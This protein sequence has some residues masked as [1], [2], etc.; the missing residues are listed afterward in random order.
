M[1]TEKKTWLI[2]GA[3]RGM[4]VDIAKT[5]LAQALVTITDAEQPPFRFIA[6][7]DALAQAEEKLAERQEQ[8]NAYRELSSSLALEEANQGATGS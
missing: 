2:T 3:G 4:G 6:G 7:A 8:I 5:K 1:T